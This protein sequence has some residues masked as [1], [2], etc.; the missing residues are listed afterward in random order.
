MKKTIL[1][2]L[3]GLCLAWTAQAQNVND[4]VQI[5]HNGS[6]Y[7]GKILKVNA[8][9]GTYFVSYDGW[10]ESWNEWVG[11]DRLK[12]G[13]QKDTATPS[14][15]LNKFKVGDR[16]LVEYGMIPEPAKVI[17]VGENN[18]EIQFDNSLYGKKVV[19][20]KQMKKM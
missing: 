11:A 5:E 2:A 1:F 15:P 14:A 20:E 7:D 8:D 13:T 12:F 17:Y 6:W 19:T 18:Y 16:V 4:K 10:S 3:L 9:E